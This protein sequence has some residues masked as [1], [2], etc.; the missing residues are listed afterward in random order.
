[1]ILIANELN[2][3]VEGEKGEIYDE[4]HLND[5]FSNPSNNDSLN[6][7]KKWWQFWK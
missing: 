1:M 5:P 2:A 7:D 6:G 4:N 3:I